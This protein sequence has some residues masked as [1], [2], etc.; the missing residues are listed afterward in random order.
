MA[1]HYSVGRLLFQ[2][3]IE[4]VHEA[5]EDQCSQLLQ[6]CTRPV[7]VIFKLYLVHRSPYSTQTSETRP[8]RIHTCC[9][10]CKC[11]PAVCINLGK[12]HMSPVNILI[13]ADCLADR[14]WSHCK[15]SNKCILCW[16]SLLARI[17]L[18]KNGSQW[19]GYLWNREEKQILL[20]LLRHTKSEVD[21]QS[22]VIPWAKLFHWIWYAHSYPTCS[23]SATSFISCAW[24]SCKR[25][26]FVRKNCTDWACF[27]NK[28]TKIYQG[29]SQTHLGYLN[30]RPPAQQTDALSTELTRLQWSHWTMSSQSHRRN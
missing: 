7:L 10:T 28:C 15:P 27:K 14:R 1:Q 12:L 20:Q 26:R 13:Q 5:R 19:W 21:P 3:G 30:L 6:H 4:E 22:H 11:F 17:L 23:K 16:K 24:R 25:R 29:L 9:V 18:M 8:S 2:E